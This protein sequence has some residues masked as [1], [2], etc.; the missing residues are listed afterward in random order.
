[1]RAH[2]HNYITALCMHGVSQGGKTALIN[3]ASSGCIDVVKALVTA[4]ADMA[5][6]DQ[7]RGSRAIR[8]TDKC[9]VND[10]GGAKDNQCGWTGG[11]GN[12]G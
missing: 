9:R 8:M 7:V 11:D 4:G 5:A 10:Q 6:K 3:V 1:M 12:W 2:Q